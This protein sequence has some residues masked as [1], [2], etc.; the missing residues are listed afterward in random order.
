MRQHKFLSNLKNKGEYKKFIKES[1][2]RNIKE[3][4][5][6]VLPLDHYENHLIAKTN[7][8]IDSL[9]DMLTET[10]SKEILNL[11]S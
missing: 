11:E 8:V 6:L 3:K 7:K 5:N 9:V 4:F 1:I 10:L 2:V